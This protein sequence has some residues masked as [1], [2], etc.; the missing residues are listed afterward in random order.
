[1]KRF[2][3]P[4]AVKAVHAMLEAEGNPVPL[5]R[6]PEQRS[7]QNERKQ[8]YSMR[9]AFGPDYYVWVSGITVWGRCRCIGEPPRTYS[10]GPT[11]PD[12]WYTLEQAAQAG[13][14]T[15]SGESIRSRYRRG[16]CPFTI[17]DTGGKA[18]IP[19]HE[20]HDAARKLRSRAAS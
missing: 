5:T 14:A 6:V 18:L 12:D 13:A 15:A 4:A 1:M 17:H 7:A 8:L 11:Q 19:A 16:T 10:G 9:R 20:I 2:T 3:A